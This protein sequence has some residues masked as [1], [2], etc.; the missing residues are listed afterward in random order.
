MKKCEEFFA[1]NKPRFL[2]GITDIN[3][4]KVDKVPEI[5]FMGK[6][7][8]GK[9]SL[10]NALTNSKISISS[11][12]PGRT[13][14]LNFFAIGNVLNIVDMPGY[15][16]AKIS[17][18]T[19]DNWIQ[20]IYDYLYYSK[21][22]KKVFLLVNCK[23]GLDQDDFDVL[24]LFDKVKIKYKIIATKSD[25]CNKMELSAAIDKIK[26]VTNDFLITS[27]KNKYGLFELRD[28]IYNLIKNE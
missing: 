5:A 17:K 3:Q 12:T 22:L 24:E 14:E 2:F 8:V 27:S 25:T 19:K 6:S 23:R 13:R 1:I 7:N 21:N 20:L 28:E 26:T 10:I 9:S 11:K 4:I 16:F 15:G 18:K